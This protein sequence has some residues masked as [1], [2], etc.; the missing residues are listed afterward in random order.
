MDD[1]VAL[2]LDEFGGGS[3][4]NI[5][6]VD[7]EKIGEAFDQ[8]SEERFRNRI[9]RLRQRRAATANNINTAQHVRNVVSGRP[10]N[11]INRIHLTVAINDAA[12]IET[13]YALADG[14]DV[15]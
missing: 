1:Q 15:S 8:R 5:G 4:A 14:R 12:T 9:P 6:P 7:K 13:R 11:H 10:D 2:A 3:P